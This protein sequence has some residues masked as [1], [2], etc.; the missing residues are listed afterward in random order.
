[1]SI[2]TKI[3]TKSFNQ[4]M[5]GAIIA[6]IR[7]RAGITAKAMSEKVFRRAPNWTKVERGNLCLTLH[8]LMIVLD[9]CKVGFQEYENEIKDFVSFYLYVLK[10][11]PELSR[12]EALL[13]VRDRYLETDGMREKRIRAEKAKMKARV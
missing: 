6:K 1:M 8:D 13:F 4:I 5:S 10:S 9:V 3:V 11:Q 2:D 7:K 12:D